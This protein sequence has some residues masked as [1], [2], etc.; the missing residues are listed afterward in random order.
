MW[1]SGYDMTPAEF[2]RELDRLW[3]DVRPFY[4]R[5]HCFVRSRLQ[6]RYGKERVKDGAPIRRTFSATCGRR[7]GRISTIS[8]SP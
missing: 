2:D 7:S 4:E 3:N 5:L 1:R 6:K 8:W